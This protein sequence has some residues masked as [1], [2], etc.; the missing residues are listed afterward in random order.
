MT[1][2]IVSSAIHVAPMLLAGIL[3]LTFATPSYANNLACKDYPII[4]PDN[5][6]VNRVGYNPGGTNGNLKG[7]TYTMATFCPA[8]AAAGTCTGESLSEKV[9]GYNYDYVTLDGNVDDIERHKLGIKIGPVFIPTTGYI[10][11]AC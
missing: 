8:A 7:T 10:P 5:A 3:A 2:L 11:G 1:N 9:Q 4:T 6:P